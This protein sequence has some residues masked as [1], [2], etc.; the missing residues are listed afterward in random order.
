VTTNSAISAKQKLLEKASGE[1]TVGGNK[2]WKHPNCNGSVS[3]LASFS[4]PMNLP[5]EEPVRVKVPVNT[6]M[7][8][9]GGVRFLSM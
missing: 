6:L 4:V 9:D 5:G 2:K 7:I 8:K 3:H 1:G